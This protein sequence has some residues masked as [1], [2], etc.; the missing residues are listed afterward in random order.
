MWSV[1]PMCVLC[2]SCVNLNFVKFFQVFHNPWYNQSTNFV[3]CGCTLRCWSNF[4]VKD[5]FSNKCHYCNNF[6]LYETGLYSTWDGYMYGLCVDSGRYE[7]LPCW[8]RSRSAWR[9]DILWRTLLYVH[10][11]LMKTVQ[12]CICLCILLVW[13]TVLV[14]IVFM[15]K[16]GSWFGSIS[17]RWIIKHLWKDRWL[18]SFTF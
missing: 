6:R 12:V 10:R 7:V 15:F 4:L 3:A 2:L 9:T 8:D 14:N 1:W 5:L 11:Y 16:E 18:R 17:E 13:P